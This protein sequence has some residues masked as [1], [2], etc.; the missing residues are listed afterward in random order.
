VAAFKIPPPDRRRPVDRYSADELH[1]ILVHDAVHSRPT[2]LLWAVEAYERIGR[3]RGN[4]PE[5]A[6]VAVVDAKEAASGNR[7]MPA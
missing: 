6:Y 3:E 5:L 2:N 1:E 4:G 7:L